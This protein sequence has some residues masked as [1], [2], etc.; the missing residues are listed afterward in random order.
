LA[1]DLNFKSGKL[2]NPHRETTEELLFT[3]V[4]WVNGA[5]SSVLSFT[6]SAPHGFRVG[7]FVKTDTVIGGTSGPSGRVT[8]VG[9]A[10][11]FTMLVGQALSDADGTFEPTSGR[12][13]VFREVIYEKVSRLDLT[14][15]TLTVRAADA[16][17]NLGVGGKLTLTGTGIPGLDNARLSVLSRVDVANF[18][19]TVPPDVVDLD[20]NQGGNQ[21]TREFTN[22]ETQPWALERD[23]V[24]A[25]NQVYFG[26]TT[27]NGQD[28][29]ALTYYR[30][31]NNDEYNNDP[32]TLSAT[33]QLVIIK[34][35][36]GS[37]VEG[38]DFGFEYN[39]GHANDPSDGYLSTN[40]SGSCQPNN[41][42]LCR[43][44]MGTVGYF[45][46]SQI[47]FYSSPDPTKLD[48]LV[49]ETSTPHG[50]T[51]GQLVS[52]GDGLRD[53]YPYSLEDLRPVSEIL[54]ANTF[55]LRTPPSD[56]FP[57][58][59]ARTAGPADTRVAYAKSYEL[60]P[61]S[62]TPELI[63]SAGSTSLVR[64]SLN[65]RVL[66]RYTFGM[67]AGAVTG[68]LAPTMGNGISGVVPSS[69]GA[70]VA[71][72]MSV[73]E[74]SP[75]SIKVKK[76]KKA[77]K[78]IITIL[79]SN[80]NT[81]TEVYIGGVKVPIYKQS[82]NRLQVK[83]PKGLSGLVDLELK[84]SLNNVLMTRK[85]NFG[86]VAEAG[87]NKRTL[88]VG[89]FAHNSRTLTASMQERINRWLDKNSDFGTL[90]CTGFTSLPRRTTDVALSTNRGKTACNFSKR[91]RAELETSVSQGI[92]DPRP[93]SNV[94]RVRLV[95]T[96]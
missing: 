4:S 89:G 28:A 24:G 37:D 48:E 92:E 73:L 26:T 15:D 44:G 9:S 35:P 95:L 94:R 54:D 1:L 21:T 32:K 71:Q 93:G 27:V 90:T 81:V 3:R 75:T 13:N 65:T 29:Y 78:Q 16:S 96:P 61:N 91:Q 56:P 8:E 63:D 5:S 50:L 53:L 82:G 14:G 7:E 46:G 76:N 47:A 31:S 70:G 69:P 17:S 62:P 79:G 42:P 18:T 68:F 58:V 85:L 84:S 39:I 77:K 86:G 2:F 72:L 60:F 67:T 64:N 74:V 23:E 20:P 34:Q 6:T 43:W 33:I 19:V 36:T 22:S 45:P 51:S 30:A 80:L 83:A 66:G 40:P 87:A 10:T 52:V 25:I 11:T 57:A 12:P 55:I 38:W 88:I 59:I 41:L 49:V